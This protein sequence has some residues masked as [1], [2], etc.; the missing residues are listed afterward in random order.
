[1][2]T[3]GV[4]SNA[5]GISQNQSYMIRGVFIQDPLIKREQIINRILNEE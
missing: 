2:M 5:P 1:M 3:N 4:V